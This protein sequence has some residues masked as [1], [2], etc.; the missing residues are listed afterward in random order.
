M[1]KLRFRLNLRSEGRKGLPQ[2]TEHHPPERLPGYPEIRSARAGGNRC[3]FTG[4][5][6]PEDRQWPVGTGNPVPREESG[7]YDDQDVCDPAPP[8]VQ[9]DIPLPR[10]P[11]NPLDKS[12]CIFRR[13][14]MERLAAKHK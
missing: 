9:N 6:R 13:E 2:A 10:D 11:R 3:E 8:Q 7:Q 4:C 14:M 12:D 1:G 5:E